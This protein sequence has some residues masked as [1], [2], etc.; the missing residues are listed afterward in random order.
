MVLLAITHQIKPEAG[1]YDGV[2]TGL[3]AGALAAGV[4]NFVGILI[5]GLD[6]HP[7]KPQDS[8]KILLTHLFAFFTFVAAVFLTPVLQRIKTANKNYWY[9]RFL[10]FISSFVGLMPYFTIAGSGLGAVLCSLWQV[11]PAA[12]MA[13]LV[14]AVSSVVVTCIMTLV[15]AFTPYLQRGDADI[16]ALLALILGL[17]GWI[18]GYA[19]A[20]LLFSAVNADVM[21]RDYGEKKD[22]LVKAAVMVG[23]NALLLPIY[24]LYLKPLVE[25]KSV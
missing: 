6:H 13:K 8:H 4:C 18:S 24:V 5:N 15:C 22:I 12:L 2:E 10:D 23:F 16:K 20:T 19:L 21:G 3:A 9:G 11:H 1:W 25:K 7:E 17:G 14:H